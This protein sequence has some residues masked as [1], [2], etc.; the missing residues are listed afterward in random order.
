MKTYKGLISIPN[1]MTSEHGTLELDRKLKI[2]G[3]SFEDFHKKYEFTSRRTLRGYTLELIHY[4]YIYSILIL[5]VVLTKGSL[6]ANDYEHACI[7]G[8]LSLYGWFSDSLFKDRKTYRINHA[9]YY[10]D[11]QKK[12]LKKGSN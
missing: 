11:I 1:Q 9:E 2:I 4:L 7:F 6:E 3:L 8:L 10:I 5:L 12:D